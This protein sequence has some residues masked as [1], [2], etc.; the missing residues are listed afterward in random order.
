MSKEKRKWEIEYEKWINGEYDER[1]NELKEKVEKD[2]HVAKENRQV[3]TK[4]YNEFKRLSNIKNYFLPQVKN[5]LELR[6]KLEE[7]RE[8]IKAEQDRR[9]NLK[10]DQKENEKLEKENEELLLEYDNLLSKGKDKNLSEEEKNEI[11][12]KKKENIEKRNINNAE[13]LLIQNKMKKGI[14]GRRI[15]VIEFETDKGL[16]ERL[17]SLSTK[18]SKCNMVCN[19]LMNGKSWKEIDIKLD[20]WE[21]YS[22]KKE[23]INKMKNAVSTNENNKDSVVIN[24]E[25]AQ[26]DNENNDPEKDEEKPEEDKSKLPVEY[27]SFAERHPI[28]AKIPFLA[29]IVDKINNKKQP[30]NS[31]EEIE[32]ISED[33]GQQVQEMMEEN[34]NNAKNDEFKKY[35][36]DVAEK[37]LEGIEEEKYWNKIN[38]E[39]ERRMRAKEEK[40]E[41]IEMARMKLSENK[42]NSANE[43]AE[44]YGGRYAE[45]DGA[46]IEDKG[47]EIG[48]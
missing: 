26:Q 8:I 32:K 25:K 21:K 6:E 48:D 19:N 1:Y 20:N 13:F 46:D 22:G 23:D 30:L 14:K 36:R 40:A 24:A 15:N 2:Q 3:K 11:E 45:Q 5:L 9:N 10:E 47:S 31:E 16:E 41:R 43:M 39:H 42:Q 27:K 29:K 37:G 34:E 38:E 7:D 17:I 28:L 35:L 12:E 4:E 44:K 18:I 33:I